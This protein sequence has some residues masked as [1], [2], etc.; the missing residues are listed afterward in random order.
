[1]LLLSIRD[2]LMYKTEAFPRL[3]F[4]VGGQVVIIINIEIV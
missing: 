4:R 3:K 1:M 2:G